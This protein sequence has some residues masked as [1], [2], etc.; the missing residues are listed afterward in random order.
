MVIAKTGLA[1]EAAVVVLGNAR[2][3]FRVDRPPTARVFLPLSVQITYVNLALKIPIVLVFQRRRYAIQEH[4]L[5]AKPIRTALILMQLN[6]HQALASLAQKTVTVLIYH[7][8]LHVSLQDH[9]ELV[10]HV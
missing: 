9:Q 7:Q 1:L 3:L 2:H 5:N 8:H 4:V 10:F 6:V